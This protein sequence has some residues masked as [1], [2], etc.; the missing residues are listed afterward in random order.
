MACQRDHVTRPPA[1]VARSRASEAQR[2]PSEAYAAFDEVY[3]AFGVAYAAFDEAYAAF[4]EVYAAFG[5]AMPHRSLFAC[6]DEVRVGE[7]WVPIVMHRR[8]E[9][10]TVQVQRAQ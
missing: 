4:Y 10:H 3:A 9:E 1:G 2:A 7:P 6:G 8:S 5:V